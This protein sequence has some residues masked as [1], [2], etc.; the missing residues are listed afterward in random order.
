MIMSMQQT[1]SSDEPISTSCCEL[2]R[3]ALDSSPKRLSDGKISDRTFC[4]KAL[5][6]RDRSLSLTRIERERE[7]RRERRRK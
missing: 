2:S 4:C 5:P 3:K 6:T 1:W 7:K